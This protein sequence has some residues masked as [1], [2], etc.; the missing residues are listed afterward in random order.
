VGDPAEAVIVLPGSRLPES[1][2]GQGVLPPVERV[3]LPDA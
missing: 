1:F 2:S 3:V